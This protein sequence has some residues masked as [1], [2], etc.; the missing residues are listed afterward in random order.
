VLQLSGSTFTSA[1]SSPNGGCGAVLA[2]FLGTGPFSGTEILLG[3]LR[4]KNSPFVL[5]LL[6]GSHA[7]KLHTKVSWSAVQVPEE[8]LDA[9]FLAVLAVLTLMLGCRPKPLFRGSIAK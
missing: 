9:D 1:C 5:T 3:G 7:K 4:P 8:P 6:S 2:S